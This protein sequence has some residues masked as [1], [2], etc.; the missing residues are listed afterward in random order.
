MN[1]TQTS[2]F[3]C[4]H[5]IVLVTLAMISA[6]LAGCEN[7]VYELE[8]RPEAEGLQRKLTVYRKR[9]VNNGQQIVALDAEELKRVAAA[10]SQEI[11]AQEI[12]AEKRHT[13]E[14]LITGAMPNDI[15]GNGSYMRWTTSLGSMTTYLERFRGRDDPAQLVTDRLAGVDEVIEH[16]LGWADLELGGDPHLPAVREFIDGELRRDLRNLSVYAWLYTASVGD[17]EQAHEE[18]SIRLGQ[19]LSERDY[20]TLEA[21]P[22]L[23][24]QFQSQQNEIE[25]LESLRPLIVRKLELKGPPSPKLSKLIENV[26]TLEASFARYAKTTKPYKKLHD[27]WEKAKIENPDVEEPDATEI[28]AESMLVA[29][30]P[31]AALLATSDELELKLISPLEP[32]MTNGSW[33]GEAKRVSWSSTLERADAERKQWPT[34]AYAIWSEPNQEM[35]TRIFGKTVLSGEPL[36]EYC[37]WHQALSQTEA[38]HWEGFLSDLKPGNGQLELIK[39][40]RLPDEGQEDEA[41]WS[42]NMR[43]LFVKVLESDE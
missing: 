17:R 27:S 12:Q 30:L 41:T 24:R 3:S 35:Q 23:M 7:N 8:L 36:A 28:L 1:A 26:A 11:S 2:G 6:A 20:L 13:F 15:G 16:L 14:S 40:F 29:F 22:Q 9:T 10:H 37:F 38:E 34:F 31:S 4:R 5:M 18:L 43:N 33:D 42:S 32:F 25:V 21:L 39:T 19:F